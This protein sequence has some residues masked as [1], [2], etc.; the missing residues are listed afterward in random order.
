MKNAARPA[1]I[2]RTGGE[3]LADG[4]I[5]QGADTVFGVPGE[6]FLAVLDAFHDR[7]DRIRFVM[8]RQEG[9]AAFMADAHAK[10]TGRPG[11]CLVTRGPGA[12][13]ASIGVH[14]AYQDS[15]PMVVLIGQVPLHHREREAFQEVEFR[16]MF[17]PMAKWVGEVEDAARLPEH[18]S[19]AF[20]LAQSGRPGPVVLTLP[21]DMLGEIAEA[22]N[23]PAANI[24]CNVPDPD[25][26]A[27]M[28]TLLEKADR[29]LVIVGGP[30]WSQAAGAALE[31]F[32]N[33]NELPVVSA[34]RCQDYVDNQHPNYVGDLGI[35]ANP[36]VVKCV[37]DADLLLVIGARLGEMTTQGYNAP[38]P[39]RSEQTLV[40][41]YPDGGELG[42]VYYPDLPIVSNSTA[43]AK[44]I[45][46]RSVSMPSGRA[47]WRRAAR[48]AYEESLISV[49]QPGDLDMGVFLAALHARVPNDAIITNG[50]GNYSAWIHKFWQFRTFRTQLAPTSG[51]MGYGVPATV[52]AKL[53][54]PNRQVIGFAGDGCFQMNGQ[55]LATI[56]QYE[57]D[58]LIIVVNNGMYG[59]IRMHQEREFPGHV[60]GTDLVNPDFTALAAAHGIYAEAVTRTS[61]A[62]AAID[63]A[64]AVK[65]PALLECRVDPEGVTPRMTL[66]KLRQT[67][68]ERMAT[69]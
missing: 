48:A 1:S 29:P 50:A 62:E 30:G 60:Y 44:A 36:G 28:C 47:Q 65:G 9:G 19:H 17:A 66:K 37:R 11:V 56:R 18:L 10:L 25:A 49:P 21:E 55:E 42:R 68:Q 39:P 45:A 38:V 3:I 4:L 27:G 53:V 24:S 26:V 13:N 63:R 46:D 15:T 12:C 16:Q 5:A 59:T 58:P 23:L 2:G 8:C 31:R 51:A 41:V 22:G 33:A 35:G 40:H 54:Y 20:H 6:S 67:A 14:T 64:L 32:A 43:F 52:A 57:L 69:G 34:L 61:E 7:T